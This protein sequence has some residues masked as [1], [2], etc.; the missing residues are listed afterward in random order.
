MTLARYAK[1]STIAF[2]FAAVLLTAPA[3]A[4]VRECVVAAEAAQSHR[5]EGHYRAAREKLIQCG[6]LS[7]PAAV[8]KDCIEWLRDLEKSAPTI[9]VHAR[10]ESGMDLADVRVSIDGEPTLE[11]LD[12]KPT[13]IDP[14]PHVLR[15]EAAGREP[16]DERIIVSAGQKDREV[17]V[18]F[19]SLTTAPPTAEGRA[20]RPIPISSIVLGG[21]A[22]IA[23]GTGTA[24]G[25][26]GLSAR[27]DVLAQPC[28]SNASCDA[29]DE[30]RV[31]GRFI[32]SDVSFAIGLLA[33]G[34]AAYFYFTR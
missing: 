9:V 14:G 10:D 13:M 16:V 31:R 17:T 5:D 6:G 20:A 30:D 8:R 11:R 25:I 15:C 18:R 19:R 26:A 2:G 1:T 28:A 22:A 24:F 33:L 29:S 27:S 4:D 3:V 32:A 12:G 34:G 21:V 7:C 23:L